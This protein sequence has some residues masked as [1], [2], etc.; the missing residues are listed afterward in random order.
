[1]LQARA[2]F[3]RRASRSDSDGCDAAD[4]DL[5][6]L[7]SHYVESGIMG[8]EFQRGLP[9]HSEQQLLPGWL[10]P[11]TFTRECLPEALVF[12]PWSSHNLP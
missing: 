1:M 6:P 9:G 7:C 4:S 5:N 10:R 3:D 8:T 12:K 11:I 2:D